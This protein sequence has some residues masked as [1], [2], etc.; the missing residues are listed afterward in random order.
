MDSRLVLKSSCYLRCTHCP[1]HHF[2]DLCVDSIAQQ[3]LM[4]VLGESR[5]T[6]MDCS[7]ALDF[8]SKAGFLV[9]FRAAKN[10]RV[11]CFWRRSSAIVDESCFCYSVTCRAFLNGVN[12][13]HYNHSGFL[14]KC[15]F[16][17]VQES[18][19]TPCIVVWG[20][21]GEAG[22]GEIL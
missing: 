3:M 6:W 10:T 16:V 13:L 5:Y 9:I 7:Q 1:R 8:S 12:Q 22:S 20:R 18:L 11:D 21:K 17:F 4:A 15:K 14:Y 2:S 19:Q